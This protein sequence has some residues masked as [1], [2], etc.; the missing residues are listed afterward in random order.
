MQ[1]KCNDK[2]THELNHMPF[3]YDVWFKYTGFR[4][5][6]LYDIEMKDGTIHEMMYPNASSFVSFAGKNV[7]VDDTDV[8]FIRLIPDTRLEGEYFN[9]GIDRLERNLEMFDDV[10]ERENP[11]GF[12]L[13][14]DKHDDSRVREIA[15]TQ[16][17][18][19]D[20]DEHLLWEATMEM[21]FGV[22]FFEYWYNKVNP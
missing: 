16:V 5:K 11:S 12:P 17:N 2:Q 18:T 22:G 20:P 3:Q 13:M 21:Y 10:I 8:A 15:S 4:Y 19:S 1:A 6:D 7:S 9:T 14:C